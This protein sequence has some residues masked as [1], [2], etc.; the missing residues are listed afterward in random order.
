MT[1]SAD[2]ARKGPD[3]FIV[4]APKAG[5]TAMDAYLGQHPEIYMAPHKETH[6]FAP[7]LIPPDERMAPEAYFGMFAA[8]GT[9][10]YFGESSVFYLVSPAA[11]RAIH[12]FCPTARILVFLRNP[13]D[14]IDSHHSQIVYEGYEDLTDLRAALDA[15][16]ARREA[17]RDGPSYYRQVVRYYRRMAAYSEQVER[18]LEVFGCAQ[19][20]ITLYDDIRA[21]L[22]G[23]YR[24]ILDFLGVDPAFEPDFGV[25]NANKVVRSS[26][27]RD[28]L[29]DPPPWASIPSRTLL[30]L[31]ARNAVKRILKRAN[32]NIVRRPP[33]PE[34][35]RRT[36]AADLRPDMQRLEKLLDRDL[37]AWYG[38]A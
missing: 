12:D 22:P 15:E 20:H 35:L 28:L 21:D 30:P 11:A 33:M 9:E 16:R 10:K 38:A 2:A 17:W 14:F 13:V 37:G 8:G 4:G 27:L 7:D 34:D 29:L 19:V 23:A 36:L 5:T 25:R 31:S 18:Y 32:T 6:F 1:A 24:R 3:L 26:R